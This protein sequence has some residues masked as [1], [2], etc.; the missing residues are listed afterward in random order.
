[1]GYLIQKQTIF[2]LMPTLFWFLDIDTLLRSKYVKRKERKDWKCLQCGYSSV[3]QT[4]MKNHVEAHHLDIGASYECQFCHAKLKTRNS[5]QAHKSR[6]R[7]RTM[8]QP[9][10]FPELPY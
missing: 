5:Y 6:C 7:D 8:A 3:Y 4:N 9:L 10:T 1:M 2:Y